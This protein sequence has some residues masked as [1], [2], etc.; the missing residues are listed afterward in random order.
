MGRGYTRGVS[1]VV[2]GSDFGRG[3]G[4]TSGGVRPGVT[5]EIVSEEGRR[6]VG[7]GHE[8]RYKNVYDQVKGLYGRGSVGE[9][10]ESAEGVPG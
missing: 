1:W 3:K 4:I 7:R 5:E 9:V 6:L 2:L 8:S 10:P